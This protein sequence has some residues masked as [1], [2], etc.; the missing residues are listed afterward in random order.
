MAELY[1]K[2]PTGS[3]ITIDDLGLVID[4][5]Q[6]ITIDEND[7]DGYLTSN[8]IDALNDSTGLVL[9][10]T[11]IGDP[12]GD[13]PKPIAIEKLTLK[14]QWRPKVGTFSNL[15]TVGNE[16]GDV[17]LVMDEGI[18]YRW[19]ETGA[20]WVQLTSTFSLSVEEYDGTPSGD[21]IQ[22]LV[23]VQ[24]EDDVYIDPTTNT[25]YIGPPDPPL[26][27]D[28]QN[29]EITGTTFYTGRLSQSNLNYK[30]SDGPG[31]SVNYITRDGTFEVSMPSFANFGNA[32]TVSAYINGNVVATVDLGEN[33]NLADMDGSQNLNNYD[34]Q[35][36]GD[37]I[38]NGVVTFAEGYLQVEEVSKFNNFKFFQGWKVRLYITDD[39]I[40][41]QGWNYVYF[42]HENLGDFGADQQSNSVDIFLDTDSGPNPSVTG[43]NIIEEL[44]VFKWLSG[45][46]FYGQD[47]TWELDFTVNDAFDNVYH[48]SSAPVVINGWP[49]VGSK[50]I[51]T[52]A[53]TVSGVQTP[54]DIGET[55][56]VNNELI[57]QPSNQNSKNAKLDVTPR[58]PYASYAPT[59]TPDLNIMIFSYGTAS[60]DLKEYFRDEQYRLPEG[61][62][63]TIQS[64]ITGLWDSTQSLVTYDGGNGLQVYDDKLVFPVEDFSDN[65]P[66][67]NPDYSILAE[68][69]N[70]VYLRAFRSSSVSRASGTLR[71]TGITVNDLYNG[72]IE[73]YIKA[74]TQTG[75]LDLSK[76][77]NFALFTGADNDGC[78]I[79][80]DSQSNSDFKFTLGGFGTENSG[81]II[82][83]KIIY[84]NN[85]TS[86]IT[87]LEIIDW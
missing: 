22:K 24:P 43:I 25:A 64:S 21:E 58:D 38:S 50:E 4:S 71:M 44:P 79:D 80:R 78:W 2:N 67:G 83:V 9:S 13:Y 17:R 16:D 26:S 45:V 62:Y 37:S 66:N 61:D 8:L 68:T 55:M 18:L 20:E 69:S 32:G 51:S 6:S 63:N 11:D 10:T 52:T 76:D 7:F 75:W 65:L 28:G 59:S 81:E 27:L 70:R 31:D 33:F 84:P 85:T 87:H 42:T 36:A 5:M 56:S 14:S 86:E 40:L 46:K 48:N 3:M 72:N 74:P 57:T 1:L 19:N 12:S 49:G 54:P 23:F 47:S 60:T 39:S 82:V 77:F 15:P 30:A 73:V 34:N 41:R 53:P 35:G 29:L